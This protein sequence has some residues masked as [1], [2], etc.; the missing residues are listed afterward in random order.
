[1]WIDYTQV[2]R[3]NEL[4]S[5]LNCKCRLVTT[6]PST[7]HPDIR[8]AAGTEVRLVVVI[9]FQG[10]EYGERSVCSRG[11]T[12]SAGWWLSLGF[13]V[14]SMVKDQCVAWGD[15]KCRLVESREY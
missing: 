10:C 4:G 5:V 11:V 14:V 3:E 8:R 9:E 6:S 7:V 15:R 2:S 12:G 1:L 13:K